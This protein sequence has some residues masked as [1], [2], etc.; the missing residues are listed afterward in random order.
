MTQTDGEKELVLGN[1]QLISLF[2]VVV[3]LCGVFFA[4]GYMIRGNT[5]RPVTANLDGNV[6]GQAQ[7]VPATV[8]PVPQSQD[9]EPPREAAEEAPAA[10]ADS[11]VTAPT[12]VPTSTAAPNPATPAVP[13]VQT[14]PA[15]DTPV[16]PEAGAIWLQVTA[17]RRADADNLVKTLRE[18]KFPTVIANSSRPELFRVLVGPYHQMS[19]VAD[20]KARLKALGF[21]N[22]FVQK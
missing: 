8:S 22:A 15:Q 20:A 5:A 9:A 2:F 11:T 21:A 10:P 19:D 3:A 16:I 17:L 7:A 1:K 12:A 4:M 13:A 18:Q 6:P 14:Q